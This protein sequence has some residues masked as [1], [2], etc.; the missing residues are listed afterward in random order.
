M[1]KTTKKLTLKPE[2]VRALTQSQL[3]VIA[4]GDCTCGCYSSPS[5]C[6]PCDCGCGDSRISS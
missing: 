6:P 3:A 2:T 4:G 1:K 5:H